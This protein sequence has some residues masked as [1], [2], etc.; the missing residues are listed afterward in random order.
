M[1][2]ILFVLALLISISVHA[3]RPSP[4]LVNDV[5]QN[6]GYIEVRTVIADP[7]PKSTKLEP[8]K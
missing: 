6:G 2:H 5:D 7:R 8:I 3:K 4:A 1:K